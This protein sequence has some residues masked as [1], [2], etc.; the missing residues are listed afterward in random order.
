MTEVSVSKLFSNSISY[1]PSA[2]A[3]M[4]LRTTFNSLLPC[5]ISLCPCF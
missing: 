3:E 2:P 4:E 1:S 5:A